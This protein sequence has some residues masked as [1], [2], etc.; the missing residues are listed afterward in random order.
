M[1]AADDLAE[2]DRLEEEIH[3]LE[4]IAR[5]EKFHK[6]E[7]YRPYPKQEEWHALGVTKRERALFAGNQE[8]KTEAGAAET[9]MHLTGRY[10]SW[11][12]GRRW[13]RPIRSWICGESGVLLRDGPQKK[14]CGN[15]GVEEDFGSGYIPKE[16]FVERPSLARGVTDLYDTGQVRHASGGIS[17]FTEKTY[18]QGRQKHQSESVDW[19]W[20]DEEPPDDIY[21]EHIAR[22][23]ATGGMIGCTFTPLLGMTDIVLKYLNEPSPDRSYVRM[24]LKDALHIPVEERER[25]LAGYPERERMARAEGIPMLG[26]GRVWSFPLEAFMEPHIP[27]DRVPVE[28]RKIWGIDFGIS[29]PFAA[30]LLAWD[31]DADIIHLLHGIRMS[32]QT[33]LS[34]VPAMRS[35][36]ANVPVA[37]PHDG[38]KRDPGSGEQLAAQYRAPGS[39]LSGLAMLGTHSTWPNGSMSTMAGVDEITDRIET[40][41]LKVSASMHEWHE[42][43]S[44]YHYD[45]KGLLVKE[46][47]DL[48]SATF[49]GLMMRRYARPVPLGGKPGNRRR[50][51]E[52][53]PLDPWTGR[54]LLSL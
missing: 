37:W 53:P 14:L 32:D 10:P 11:W 2:R 35:I 46:R 23:T 17:T 48:L 29:H 38:A 24:G 51:R 16:C 47:D 25:I 43:Y 40:G 7:G 18:E 33:K 27:F 30:V 45:E 52:A 20:D 54:P 22:I 44:L 3:L 13:T 6:L 41:R 42:E 12:K 21:G 34:H 49:K 19:I 8:G 15:P 31:Q 50:P 5:Y 36:A 39:G 28:W 4:E 26:R 1:T 9:A